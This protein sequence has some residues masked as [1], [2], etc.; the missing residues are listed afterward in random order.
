M[1]GVLGCCTMNNIFPLQIRWYTKGRGDVGDR[2]ISPGYRG[3][4]AILFCMQFVLYADVLFLQLSA[5]LYPAEHFCENGRH[6]PFN[7]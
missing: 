4:K 7:N 1:L 5:V 2:E 3:E 6:F